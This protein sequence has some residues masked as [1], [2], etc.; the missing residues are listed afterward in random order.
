MPV[1]HG[2]TSGCTQPTT[3]IVLVTLVVDFE[4]QSVILTGV[5]ATGTQAGTLQL[6]VSMEQ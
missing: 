5:D 6:E 3:T 2:S 1:G 4:S